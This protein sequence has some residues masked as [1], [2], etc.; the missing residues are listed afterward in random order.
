MHKGRLEAFS[1]GV[2]AI[3]I[4]IM[5]LEIKVPHGDT[6]EALI[7]LVP[8]FLSYILSF[9]Y[10]GIYWNN[11]HHTMQ[12]VKSVD[13]KIL[14]GNLHL[15]FWLSL[16]PFTTGW[17]GEN[18][19][20]QIPVIIYGVNLILAALAYYIWG[21][22]LVTH[23]GHGSQIAQALGANIKGK[24]SLVGYALGIGGSFLNPWLGF[25]FY[26][27]VAVMWLVPDRRMEK[28]IH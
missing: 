18:H 7:P 13:G 5:V 9:V 14:W 21:N 20:A 12:V 22:T 2:I 27:L 19:F 24:I 25:F 26:I 4:T 15:L 8:V 23:H 1:D 16:L 6:L 11:H 3:I 10:V 17:M 28:V